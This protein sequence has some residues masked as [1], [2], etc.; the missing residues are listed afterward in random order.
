MKNIKTPDIVITTNYLRPNYVQNF[1]PTKEE[2]IEVI[3]DKI[4]LFNPSPKKMIIFGDPGEIDYKCV[5]A[6][7]RP[8]TKKRI[9]NCKPPLNQSFHKDFQRWTKEY[10]FPDFVEF[11]YPYFDLCDDSGCKATNE[12]GLLN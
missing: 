7:L 4:A 2:V 10:Q 12:K 1:H 3:E 6:S 8:L 9:S 5:S 11:L